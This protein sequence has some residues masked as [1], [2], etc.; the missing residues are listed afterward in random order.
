MS[1]YWRPTPVLVLLI[2]SM[3]IGCTMF[4]NMSR[5]EEFTSTSEAFEHAFVHLE[6][7]TIDAFLDPAVRRAGSIKD[8]YQNI[9]VVDYEVGQQ[10]VSDS[11]LEITQQVVIQY[12][13]LDRNVLK[14]VSYHPVWRYLEE[15]KRWVLTT[16]LPVL[17]P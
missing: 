8:P 12:F 15:E 5:Q 14:T 17:T 1:A 9:K 13:L 7:H 10:R 4:A 2:T 3:A 11:G 6:I 16:D